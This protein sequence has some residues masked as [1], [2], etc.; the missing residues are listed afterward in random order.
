MNNARKF[1][2]S[3]PSQIASSDAPEWIRKMSD[4]YVKTG[5]VRAEDAAQLA[6]TLPQGTQLS[7]SSSTHEDALSA[8]GCVSCSR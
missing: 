4:H 7:M 8:V 5:T 2:G 6:G 1:A 3:G